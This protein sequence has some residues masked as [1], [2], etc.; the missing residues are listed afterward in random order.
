MEVNLKI[1]CIRSKAHSPVFLQE[2][3]HTRT[4]FQIW[5]NF[6]SKNAEVNNDVGI[7]S[8]QSKL[9]IHDGSWNFL[10]TLQKDLT[11]SPGKA[12]AADLTCAAGPYWRRIPP[13]VR[14]HSS[15]FA[16][17]SYLRLFSLAAARITQKVVCLPNTFFCEGK[18]KGKGRGSFSSLKC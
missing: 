2:N 6:T 18:G 15:Y 4:N 9:S 13:I 14:W 8:R 11:L 16:P 12:C 10:Q 1:L 3:F 17:S 5:R 7:F